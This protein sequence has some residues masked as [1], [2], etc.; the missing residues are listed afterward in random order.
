MS[1]DRATAGVDVF[2]PRVYA[3]GVPYERFAHLR[4]ITPVAWHEERAVLGW[5]AGPG[6]W[7]VSRHR[8]VRHVGRTPSAFSA[9]LGGT[10]IRDVAPADLSFIRE[11]LL[12]LDPPAHTRV[13]RI[14]NE[15][16]APR[17]VRALEPK[18]REHARRMVEELLPR[19]E[20]DFAED[21]GAE[22]PLVTLV[23]VMGVPLSDRRL[24]L[25]WTN[26]VI[27]YQ[28]Q[29]FAGMP[30][31]PVTGAPINPRSKA[32]L[33][34][35]FEYA[36]ALAGHKRK[37]PN[38]DLISKLLQ[39][40]VDGERLSDQELENMFFLF[41]IAGNDTTHSA[42][43]GGMLALM[44]NPGQLAALLDDPGLLPSAVEEMLRY[45]PPV[46]H[47]RRTAT[48]DVELHGQRIRAGEKVV[49]FYVSANRDE[50]AFA[51]PDRFDIRRTPNDHVTFGAGPHFCLGNALARLQMRVTFEEVL[52]RM[53]DMEL[54]GPVQRLRSNFINGIKHMPVRFRAG[55]APQREP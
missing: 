42:I 5:P 25:D 20:C 34:D 55:P 41:T 28:D 35:M 49:V 17:N 44:E 31:D 4:A 45:A 6:F 22:L 8:D 27:G 1:E 48:R 12:N 15:G 47:F 50:E 11:N 54:T 43:P 19:G 18:I 53:A 21:I 38:D 3:D 7:A 46:I 39:A 51:E 9:N 32:A 23:E 52:P 24:L 2:D 10:Q 40:E 16:F 26:R 33:A 14:V 30:R 29:E 37:H 13:R 36:H